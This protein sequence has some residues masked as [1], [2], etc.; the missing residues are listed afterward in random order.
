MIEVIAYMLLIILGFVS[1]ILL[2]NY[3]QTKMK[4]SVKEALEKQFVR[5][6]ANADAD[7]PCRPYGTT[8]FLEP[9][10]MRFNQGDPDGDGPINEAFMD[11][12]HSKGRAKTSFR[13]S[14]LAK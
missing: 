5:L 14:D 8:H 9:I 6:K 2:D 3:Y 12:L 10:P 1:G 7:D 13:K 4:L 11:E